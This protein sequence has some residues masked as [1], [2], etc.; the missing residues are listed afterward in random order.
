MVIRKSKWNFGVVA[1]RGHWET[2]DTLKEHY[3]GVDTMKDLAGEFKI[4]PQVLG[5]VIKLERKKDQSSRYE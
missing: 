5:K 1:D 2:L 4:Y 3:G